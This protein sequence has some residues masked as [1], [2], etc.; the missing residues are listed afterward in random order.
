MALLNFPTPSAPG[1]QTT[2]NGN[3]W[4]WNGTSW[5]A[6]NNLSLSTQVSGVL[7][8]LYGGTGKALSSITVGS[9]LY[10]DTSSSFT[11]L[12]PSITSAYVL[13]SAGAGSPPYWKIDDSGT[14]SVGSGNT[15]GFTYYSGLNTVTS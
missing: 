7:G 8:T 12:A 1:D 4:Q 11:T 2:Q 15:F 13:A 10:A 14:G 9:L 5:V 3:T 6:F